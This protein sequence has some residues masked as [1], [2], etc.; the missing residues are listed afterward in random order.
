MSSSSLR[1][2]RE[3]FLPL[4]QRV[5]ALV[6]AR[7][8]FGLQ[9]LAFAGREPVLVLE[10]PH[11]AVDLREV[12]GELRLARAEVFARRR[13]HGRVQPETAG[14]LERETAARRCRTPADR[15]A[16]TWSASNPNAALATPSVVEA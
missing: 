15:S 6:H 5:F 10:R 7:L 1:R 12:L 4:T 9:R 11:V 13:D 16:R 2:L 14:D 8:G 3:R